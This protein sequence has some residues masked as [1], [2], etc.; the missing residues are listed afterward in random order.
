MKKKIALLQGGF[1]GEVM[2][3]VTQGIRKRIEEEHA[4]LYI[5]NCYGGENED[6]LYNQGE[7]NIFTLINC[8]DYDGFIMAS[9]NITS[10]VEREKLRKMLVTSGKPAVSMEHVLE[11]LHS[12]GCENYW[13]V[14]EMTTHMI[15]KHGAKRIFFIGGP[16][17][18]Y[19]TQRRMKGVQDA[20]S[21]AHLAMDDKWFR[22]Y[23]YTYQDGYQAF[24]DF[25][26]AGCGIP[27]CIIAANDQMAV[28]YCAAASEQELYAPD[29]FL[30]GGF[31][32][33]RFSETYRPRL[34][35]V[36]REKL[37]AGY[38]SCDILFR[39]IR[40]EVVPL[41]T[42]LG[43]HVIYR[44][45]C[46]CRGDASEIK[47]GREHII[48]SMLRQT[49][50][51]GDVQ[52]MHKEL[53][54]STDWN[55]YTDQL[56]RY[57][58]AIGC[59][60]MY[61][62]LNRQE[63]LHPYTDKSTTQ[64]GFDEKLSILFA[65]ENGS[66]KTYREFLN[67]RD[68]FPGDYEDSRSHTF[69]IL[70]IHFQEKELGY[71]VIIDS[72]KMVDNQSLFSWTHSI[73]MS[74]EI[75][76]ERMSLKQANTVLDALSVED[77]LTGV[78]NRIGL[79][80]HAENLLQTDRFAM[81]HT[82]IVFIDVNRLKFIN[83]TYGHKSGDLTIITVANALKSAC[84]EDSIIVRYGGDEFVIVVPK[85][86]D[87]TGEFLK[88]RINSELEKANKELQLAYEISVSI[89]YV[90]ANPDDRKSLEEYVKEA[91]ATMYLEKQKRKSASVQ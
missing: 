42:I 69:L 49:Q 30:I 61:I 84:L 78:Y 1:N 48:E 17:D 35:T 86:N 50:L 81:H 20:M 34:T 52:K 73:N 67:V 66:R 9:N 31:D 63:Y 8:E 10:A 25:Q 71:C 39:L 27:D 24:Y 54:Q 2:K 60:S 57:I 40:G 16:K 91:D 44:S 46:G 13:T 55:E 43:S 72:L 4:D 45:S 51:R 22:H 26:S 89:G 28:G 80:R 14:R 47:H 3:Y 32:N 23:N 85:C 62:M 88:N 36:D 53:V 5:F 74:M 76:L 33:S 77:A 87:N 21:A 29:D 18:N 7:Y 64:T 37:D 65:W 38:H 83:D 75:M 19:E 6:P 15:E 56:A 70:P 79:T 68:L 58:P 41:N 12:V 90:C 82:L 59:P 11:G